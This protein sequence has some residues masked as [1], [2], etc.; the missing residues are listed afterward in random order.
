MSI[1]Y[2]DLWEDEPEFSEA[3]VTE[4]INNLNLCIDLVEQPND[5]SYVYRLDFSDANTRVVLVSKRSLNAILALEKISF[6]DDYIE[7]YGIESVD[8][9]RKIINLLDTHKSNPKRF[10]SLDQLK[11]LKA[12]SDFFL[13]V[14]GNPNNLAG[15]YYPDYADNSKYLFYTS[16]D[17]NILYEIKGFITE[18]DVFVV[19]SVRP[20]P[21]RNF[22][23][24]DSFNSAVVSNMVMTIPSNDDITSIDF[25][26]DGYVHSPNGEKY[27]MV[28]PTRDVN[29][30]FAC[31]IKR[32]CLPDGYYI[33]VQDYVE[34]YAISNKRF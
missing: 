27:A 11:D 32:I 30:F 22:G 34:N 3:D 17:S 4:L 23:S 12:R 10:F 20:M 14:F 18:S 19:T 2:C 33:S 16:P 1:N 31:G 26:T 28:L 13:E 24:F 15:I 5:N 21:S 6:A 9:L 7:N 29:D 8:Y 25:A